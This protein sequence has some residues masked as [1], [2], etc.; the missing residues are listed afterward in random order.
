MN[1]RF[2]TYGGL[3]ALTVLAGCG[4]RS[5]LFDQGGSD[6]A[7]DVA[8]DAQPADA[9][10]GSDARAVD[11]GVDDTTVT[12]KDAAMDAPRDSPRGGA[13][14]RDACTPRTCAGLGFNCGSAPDGCGGVLDC[15]SCPAGEG[16]GVDGVAGQCSSC[17][18]TCVPVTCAGTG[19]LPGIISDGCGNILDCGTCSCV[20]QG[21]PQSCWGAVTVPPDVWLNSDCCGSVG[22]TPATCAQLNVFCAE[23]GDGCGGLLDCGSCKPGGT[24]PVQPGECPTCVPKT[25]ASAGSNCGA[26]EDGCGGEIDC[27]T[28]DPCVPCQAGVCAGV[29]VSMCA[30]TTCADLG[31]ECGAA[32][33]GCNHAL[34]CGTCPGSLACAQG[35]CLPA[36]G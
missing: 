15:G 20:Y 19:A 8:A 35:V 36:C 2:S 31:L 7:S 17:V 29:L 34:D 27:G 30:P 33:D 1:H 28:C 22:C 24:C 18:S 11:A 4:S 14:A 25:C 12:R 21:L 9:G 23:V 10:V 26:Q 32:T 6:V 3:V 5:S 16:C 13:D